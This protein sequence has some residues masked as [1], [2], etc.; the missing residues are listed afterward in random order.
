MS[1]GHSFGV[2]NIVSTGSRR[3]FTHCKQPLDYSTLCQQN[4]QRFRLCTAS[5]T[6]YNGPAELRI[7]SHLRTA[8]VKLENT[9]L[10]L[11]SPPSPLPPPHLNVYP[12]E[13]QQWTLP[14]SFFPPSAPHP[15]SPPLLPPYLLSVC[16]IRR[17]SMLVR[18]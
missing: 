13:S 4:G 14:F 1:S 17:T 11:W 15:L 5:K 8:S 3:Y 6:Q 18:T 10:P 16:K 12:R 9:W 2:W 7:Y